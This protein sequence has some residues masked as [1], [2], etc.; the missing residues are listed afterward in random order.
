MKVPCYLAVLALSL[1]ATT[2]AFSTRSALYPENWTPGFTDSQGRY[3]HDFSYAGYQSG[4]T[5]VPDHLIEPV[6]DV[7]AEYGA[8]ATGVQDATAAIQA[9]I[10]A[11]A[12]AGGGTVYLPQGTYRIRVPSPGT[13]ALWIDHSA[14]QLIGDGPN[15]TFIFNDAVD[16][17]E[18]AVI[19]VGPRMERIWFT[20]LNNQTTPLAHDAASRDM[21][22]V[23]TDVTPFSPGDSIVATMDL[24]DALIAEFS[25]QGKDWDTS[26]MK[27]FTFARTIVAIDTASNTITLDAPIRF[28]LETANNAR[29]YRVSPYVEEV[30]LKGFSI[31][32]TYHPASSG[33]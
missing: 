9:A 33:F 18:T 28:K 15:K 10:D 21:E 11:A 16:V 31:G 4:E 25:M 3:L 6:F 1:I 5:A 32:N 13:P 26:W 8:D 22:L 24:T 27:G 19:R 20:P 23:L 17:R 7:V 2:C 14:I 30:G 29:I 12:N